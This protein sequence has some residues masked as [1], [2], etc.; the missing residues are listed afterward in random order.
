MDRTTPGDP[1]S[2]ILFAM[3]MNV[4]SI[5]LNKAAADDIF[6]Y[7]PSCEN[8]NL[9]HLSFADDLL[10]FFDGS[11][12][13]VAGVFTVL[14]QFEKMSGLAVNI[15][16]TSMFCSGVPRSVLDQLQNRF[17]LVPGSLPIRYLGLPL[18]SRKLSI[19]DCDPLLSKIRMKM[20]SWLHRKLSLAG[21]LRLL[22]SVIS[23]LIM[24]WTQAFFLPK[25]VIK[26]I[27]SLCS[28]FL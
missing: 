26:K 16:K 5:M 23:G 20:N 18:C 14:S 17:S 15:S 28:S 2:P 24:F 9:T 19:A 22:S 13:S 27:N 3:A 25:T 21:R 8:V 6:N 11:I 4:L 7:H 1:L 10:I 12:S